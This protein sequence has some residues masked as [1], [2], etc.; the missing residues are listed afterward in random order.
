[1][2]PKKEVAPARLTED[3]LAEITTFE[4]A[5][6]AAQ[7]VGFVVDASDLGD[8]FALLKDKNQLVGKDL[9]VMSVRFNVGDMGKY[10]I[11]RVVTS[12]NKKYVLT[13]GSTGM[14]SQLEQIASK[15]EAKGVT[16]AALRCRRGLIRSDYEVEDHKGN[17]IP[18]TTY[19]FDVSA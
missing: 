11:I 16:M 6:L 9:I 3:M 14:C 18:A 1:M 4:E 13:D 12:E 19:Y 17:M 2:A 10:A 5:L 7:E 15:L 8:G